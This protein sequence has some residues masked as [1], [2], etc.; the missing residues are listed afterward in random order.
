M[1]LDHS[2]DISDGLILNDKAKL[3]GTEVLSYT[4]N[5]ERRPLKTLAAVT[6]KAEIDFI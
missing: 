4:A 2:D 5:L 3:A 1:I 6:V